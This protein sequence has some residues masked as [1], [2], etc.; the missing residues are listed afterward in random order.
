MMESKMDPHTAL[1]AAAFL[2]GFVSTSEPAPAFY[3]CEVEPIAGTNAYQFV[4]P[5][6]AASATYDQ[7]DYIT[8]V[9]SG[10]EQ[11]V[12]INNR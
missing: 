5:A 3:G 10:V 11:Q 2:G 4:D 7:T 1:I 12:P 9:V 6:C 8:V